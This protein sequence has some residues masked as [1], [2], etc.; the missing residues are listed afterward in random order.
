MMCMC[1]SFVWFRL[2]TGITSS[3]PS[4]IIIMSCNASLLTSHWSIGSACWILSGLLE[5]GQGSVCP[6]TVTFLFNIIS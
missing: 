5:G 4:V 6:K 2:T 1:A 3:A